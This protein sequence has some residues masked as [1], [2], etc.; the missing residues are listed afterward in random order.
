MRAL[1]L[2]AALVG[3]FALASTPG[4]ATVERVAHSRQLGG[5]SLLSEGG[6]H[7][8][9]RADQTRPID[10]PA[11][12]HADALENWGAR[13]LIAGSAPDDRGTEL[14][15]VR[16][17]DRREERLPAPP[18][19]VGKVRQTAVPLLD[20]EQLLG[21]AWLEGAEARSFDV[22]FAA[23]RG[24]KFDA[25]QLVA[26]AGP[27]SQLALSGCRL[28]DGRLLLLWAGYDGLDDE[29]WFSVG[30]TGGNWSAA[31]RTAAE[32]GVPDI[33]PVVAPWANGALVWWSRFD[34]SEYRLMSARF[35]GTRMHEARFVAPPGSLYPSIEAGPAGP[36]ILYRDARRSEWT[37]AQVDEH[38]ALGRSARMEGDGDERPW[39]SFD[40]DAV[41]WSF[42]ERQAVSSWQ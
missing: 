7:R 14:F 11:G 33:T 39:V 41:L 36:A 5:A 37:L 4:L 27:G 29:I 35:D 19:R 8:I 6:R 32:N 31:K 12:A 22:R 40:G 26:P 2:A 38:G 42:G 23:W 30:K 10:L 1:R 17:D 28:A 34:G 24:G 20:G 25:P 18:G 15:L 3:F 21:V 13:W 16:G 9:E